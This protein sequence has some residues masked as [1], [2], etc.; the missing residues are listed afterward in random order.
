[1]NRRDLL[2]SAEIGSLI[3]LAGCTGPISPPSQ[4]S[5]DQDR[6]QV[7]NADSE[8]HTVAL[9]V[10]DSPANTVLNEQFSLQPS[11]ESQ[12]YSVSG[13]DYEILITVD[14]DHSEAFPWRGNN[15]PNS[16][17]FHIILYGKSKIDRQST[18]CD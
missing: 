10:N 14:S 8:R 4:R 1:M 9:T 18:A 17:A 2:V 15:C 3:A 5:S 16:H 7:H 11:G 13:E 12:V 6:L